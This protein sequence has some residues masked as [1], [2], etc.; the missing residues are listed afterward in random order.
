[1]RLWRRRR[2]CGGGAVGH[3]PRRISVF[4]P[5]MISLVAHF[6]AVFNRQK[7]RKPWN[8]DFTVQ[9]R[10]YK[11]YKTVEI[12]QKFTIRP[13]GGGVGPSPPPPPEYATD[14]LLLA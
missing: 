2:K 9:S 11:A 5:K 1:M 10:N 7:T 14:L 4:V 3:L 8:T 13:R 12:I 6:A